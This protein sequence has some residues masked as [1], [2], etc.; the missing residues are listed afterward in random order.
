MHFSSIKTFQIF[1]KIDKLLVIKKMRNLNLVYLLYKIK[2][3]IYQ[4]FKLL[5]KNTKLQ[6]QIQRILM[7]FNWKLKILYQQ[8]RIKIIFL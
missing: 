4:R 7:I 1:K 2:Y 5:R 6:G 8:I 3:Q